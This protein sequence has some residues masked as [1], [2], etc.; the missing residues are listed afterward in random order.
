MNRTLAS[1]ALAAA[2]AAGCA[3]TPKPEA[4]QI[5]DACALLKDNKSWHKA[6]RRSAKDWGAPMGFQLAVIRQES[7]F[8]SKARPERGD[9]RWLG[10]LPGKRPST[11]YGYAQALD[12]TWAEYQQKT[13]NG[14]A[15]RRNFNDAVDFIGWYFSTTGERAGVGQYDYRAHYLAYHEGAGGYMR[16]TWRDKAWLIQTADRVAGH[17]ARYE[18]QISECKAL[19]PKFLGIF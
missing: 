8:D 17:A 10:L 18:R 5:A 1:L 3:S 16:G 2:L 7:S 13:G 6:M 4:H 12:T 19:Q 15:S 11:A 14:G 9:R